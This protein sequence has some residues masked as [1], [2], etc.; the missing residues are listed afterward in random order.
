M[1][2]TYTWNCPKCGIRTSS[3]A[4]SDGYITF[5]CSNCDITIKMNEDGY[6]NRWENDD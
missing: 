3:T 5:T 1:P 6:V 2:E 4:D